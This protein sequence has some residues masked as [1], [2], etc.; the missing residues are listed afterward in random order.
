MIYT[1]ITNNYDNQR[2]DI[3]CFTEDILNNPFLSAKKYKILSHLFDFDEWSI[4]VDGHLNLPAEKQ[5]DL[6]SK[7]ESSGKEIGVFKHPWRDCIYDEAKV[8][9]EKQLDDE[10]IVN[11]Q[12][13]KYRS[14][15]YPEHNGLY[16][17]GILV[18]R[19]T[20]NVKKLNEKWWDE[21]SQGSIR[22]QLSFPYVFRNVCVFEG[23]IYDYRIGKHLKLSRRKV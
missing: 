12:V 23:L 6:T 8:I 18:R 16:A 19:H 11:H 13:E 4:W 9:I 22:D 1:A 3:K 14:E 7:V 10:V 2:K 21:I 5:K 15:D 17:C 20:E